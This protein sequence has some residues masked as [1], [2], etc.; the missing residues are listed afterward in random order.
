[1]RSIN[2][3]FYIILS[4]C[5]LLFGY[6]YIE[7]NY[8]NTIL[9]EEVF[10]DIN[11]GETLKNIAKNLEEQNLIKN[12]YLFYAYYYF[13]YN[14][15][16]IK[17]G[18]YKIV[19]KMAISEIA[20]VIAN[21]NIVQ[22]KI[23]ILEGWTIEDIGNYLEKQGIFSAEE[24][25]EYAGRSGI[26]YPGFDFSNEFIF[27]KSK[28]DNTGLE[29]FLFPDTYYINKNDSPREVVEMM[30]ENYDR[31]AATQNEIRAAAGQSTDKKYENLKPQSD[32]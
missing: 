3:V 2:H 17:A 19:P 22:K 25:F 27:L 29:G 23:K 10:F 31:F 4:I 16:E 1:M 6:L 26:G 32:E 7:I 12:N 30:L 20:N 18:T 9:S 15:T 13:T 28:P 8:F 21:E 24:F 14:P 5:F 11:E